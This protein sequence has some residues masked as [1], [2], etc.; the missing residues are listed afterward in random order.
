MRFPADRDGGAGKLARSGKTACPRA[1]AYE[2]LKTFGI[3]DKSVSICRD[4]QFGSRTRP[5]DYAH[6]DRLRFSKNFAAKSVDCQD[7][8]E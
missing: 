2:Q 5:V 1:A 8:G 3:V 4:P 6:V 7:F